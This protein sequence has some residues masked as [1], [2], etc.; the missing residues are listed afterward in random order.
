MKQT[1]LLGNGALSSVT[2]SRWGHV[3]IGLV[4]ILNGFNTF[5]NDISGYFDYIMLIINLGAG[6]YS[7]LYAM[8][9]LT[10]FS[11]FSPKIKLTDSIIQLKSGVMKK[12]KILA[13]AEIKKIDFH[14]Y[15][16]D[17][18]MDNDT[19]SFSYRSNAKISK[20]IKEALREISKTKN[21]EITG[22]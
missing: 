21:I 3:F 7:L 4:L 16:I 13:W 10:K 15:Q 6:I 22:G 8:I 5:L 1:I 9:A 17:F 19:F 20:R 14:A 11:S 18:A 12:S 2:L